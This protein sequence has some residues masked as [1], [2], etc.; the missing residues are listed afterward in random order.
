MSIKHFATL[1]RGAFL[2]VALSGTAIAASAAHAGPFIFNDTADNVQ[3]QFTQTGMTLAIRLI[4]NG[5]T[6][7]NTDL[8]DG[9]F[10]NI[11]GNSTVNLGSGSNTVAT[12]FLT[13]NDNGKTVSP[14]SANADISGS[15]QLKS[16]GFTFNSTSYKYGLSAVGGNGLFASNLFTLGNGSDDYG[17]VGA[18][19]NVPEKGL[20]QFP[21]AL[22]EIDFKLTLN[23]SDIITIGDVA[24]GFNSAL[25]NV[26]AG[27]DPPPPAVAEPGSLALLGFGLVGLAALRR[28]A[29]A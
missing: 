16:T 15:W 4:N 21:L 9:L 3:A 1:R 25:S 22:G 26:V 11:S 14:P 6:G 7:S 19:T 8:L 29:K 18:N 10:F 28:R 2:A 24:F 13:S 27:I 20:T 5:T 23:S 17:L 12:K